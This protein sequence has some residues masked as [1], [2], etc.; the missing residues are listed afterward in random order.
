MQSSTLGGPTYGSFQVLCLKNNLDRHALDWFISE[1]EPINHDSEIAHGLAS[2]LCLMHEQFVTSATAQQATKEFEVVCYNSATGIEKL[3]SEFICMANKMREPPLAFTV[4]QRFM[5]LITAGAHNKLVEGGLVAEYSTLEV[6]KNHA[7][8]VLESYSDEA[9]EHYNH[10]NHRH[11]DHEDAHEIPADEMEG[12]W[13]RFQ[14]DEIFDD[15]DPD[16]ICVGA[17]CYAGSMCIEPTAEDP[18]IGWYVLI[19]T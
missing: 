11:H 15:A 16:G 5:R 17:M 2:I 13:G 9:D 12:L 10:G 18:P 4:R 14:Y 1:V 6:F 19:K 8:R 3:V 7:K